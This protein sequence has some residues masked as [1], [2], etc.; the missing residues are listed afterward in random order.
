[1]TY[2]T[3]NAFFVIPAVLLAIFAWRLIQWRAFAVAFL[4]LMAMTALFDNFIIGS[5]VVAYDRELIS[6]IMVGFAPIEDFAYTLVGVI[7]IPLS[8]WWLERRNRK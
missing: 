6:G 8:W 1:M 7:L 5:G 2:L 3:L 4:V